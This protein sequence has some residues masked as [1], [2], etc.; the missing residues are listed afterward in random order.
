MMGA[1]VQ[2]QTIEYKVTFRVYGL[3]PTHYLD[4]ILTTFCACAAR[5]QHIGGSP[6]ADGKYLRYAE[7]QPSIVKGLSGLHF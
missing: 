7:T 2:G 5:V 3:D 4:L 6:T 1:H